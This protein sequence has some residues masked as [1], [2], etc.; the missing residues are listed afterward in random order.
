MVDFYHLAAK[1]VFAV[2]YSFGCSCTK[3][4]RLIQVRSKQVNI[5]L[6]GATGSG[7]S[8]TVNAM[9]DMNVAKVGVGVDPETTCISKAGDSKI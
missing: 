2:G 3:L 8:S 6:V 5:M 7:K 4:S 1:R 9:F